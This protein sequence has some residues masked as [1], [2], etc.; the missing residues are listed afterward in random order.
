MCWIFLFNPIVK[1]L[2][3]AFCMVGY[4]DIVFRLDEGCNFCNWMVCP[5]L[6]FDFWVLSSQS[7]VSHSALPFTAYNNVITITIWEVGV[8][9][10]LL[11]NTSLAPQD[12]CSLLQQFWRVKII[13]KNLLCLFRTESSAGATTFF[14]TFS[15]TLLNKCHH[16]GHGYYYYENVVT[17]GCYW[18]KDKLTH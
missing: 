6:K 10:S 7:Q 15:P 5:C 1:I 13:A 14:F 2:S 17:K 8:S 4:Y 11:C 16:L 18:H 3:H 12:A 9:L